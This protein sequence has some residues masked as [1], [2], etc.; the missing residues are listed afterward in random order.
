MSTTEISPGGANEASEKTFSPTPE[1]PQAIEVT[2]TIT[3]SLGHSNYYEQNGLRIEG[4][5]ADHSHYNPVIAFTYS[6]YILLLCL[7]NPRGP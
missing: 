4:D 6:S 2:R 5:G 7:T 1:E 3:H